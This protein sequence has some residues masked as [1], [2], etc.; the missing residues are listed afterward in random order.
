M[1]LFIKKRIFVSSFR[2]GKFNPNLICC[3]LLFLFFVCFQND[4][5][6][7]WT[8]FHI[9][10]FD[11]WQLMF[12]CI[13]C[14]QQLVAF[15]LLCCPFEFFHCCSMNKIP[16]ILNCVEKYTDVQTNGRAGNTH[17]K[18]KTK[19]IWYLCLWW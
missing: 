19:A 13:F 4:H 3:R 18:E 11:W 5:L 14:F 15:F 8:D 7:W 9:Q 6:L 16:M 1:V 17:Y 2:Y 12:V 10:C